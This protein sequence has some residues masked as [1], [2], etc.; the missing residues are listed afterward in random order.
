[1]D[2]SPSHVMVWT[3]IDDE[4]AAERL[5]ASL[6]EHSLAACV[7]RIPIQS[8]YRWKGEVEN[9][10]EFLLIAKTKSELAPKVAEFIRGQH[11]YELPEII[12]VP[13]I[14]GLTPYLQWISDETC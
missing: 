2:K 5:A 7:Q 1:M 3:T 14:G 8:I 6:V 13:I 11:P 4:V 12:T 10:N 9:A